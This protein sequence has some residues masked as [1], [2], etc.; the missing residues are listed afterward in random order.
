MPKLYSRDFRERVV[1]YVEA[2]HSRH[3]A[4]AHFAVSVSFVVNLMTAYRTRG[5][6]PKPSGGKRHEDQIAVA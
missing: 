1:A 4:A 5:V 3:A 6:E 2:G